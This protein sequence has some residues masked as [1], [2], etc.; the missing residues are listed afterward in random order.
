[1]GL[2]WALILRYQIAGPAPT[3]GG[4]KGGSKESKEAQKKRTSA[5]K[6]LLGWVNASL[7]K[8]GIR[9]FTTDW[10]D[11]RNLSALVDYCKPGLI[12]DHASLDP[13]NHLENVTKA[14]DIA[15][16]ELNVPQV[17]HPEDLAVDKPD[18]LSVMTYISGFCRPN[19][20]GPNSLLD[21]INERIPNIPATN[22]TTDWSDG[23]RLGALTDSVSGGEFPEADQMKEDDDFKNCQ[24]AMDAAHNLLG[25][26][27]TVPPEDF[28]EE[29]FDQLTRM[30]YLSQFRHAKQPNTNLASMM[31]AVG[32]GI[33][34]DS[35]EKE[36][37][38]L[39]RGPRIPKWA[40]LDARVTDS[41]GDE[42][43]LKRQSTSSKAASYL[44][45]PEK[46]GDYIIDIKL[47]S[48]PIPNS[49]F[50][51]S[52]TP[53][54]N[55]QGCVATGNGLSKARVGETSSFSVNCEQGGP[56][57]LMVEIEGPNGNVGTEMKEPK[58]RN[59]DVSFSPL[60]PGEH[61]ISINW[62]EK[63]I[64]NSPFTCI[65][66][67]P[68]KCTASGP[69]LTRASVEGPQTFNV[70]AE[71]AG[72]GKL[73]ATV[74]GPDGDV[75]IEISEEGKGNYKCTYSPKDKGPHTINISWSGV[76]I[77]G[78]P[79]KVNVT[80]PGDASKCVV[81]DL[82][83]GR[84]RALKTYSFKVDTSEAG[85]GELTASAH[86]PS[87]PESCTVK[88]TSNDVYAVNVTS[89]EVG[90]LRVEASYA[91]SPIPGSPFEFTVNDPRKVK[92]NR[93]AIESG[94]YQVKQPIDFRVSAQYAG[95]GDLSASVRGPE[96]EEGVEIKDQGDKTY[97]M[98]YSP[99]NGGSHA[100]NI[101]FDGDEIPDVPMRIFVEAGSMADNVVVTQPAP[102]K[103][104]A[105]IIEHPYT[106]K[107]NTDGA[108]EGTLTAT[109]HGARTGQ[110]PKVNVVDDGNGRYSVSIE[111]EEPDTYMV[112]IQ[113]GEENV[114]GSPFSLSV[115]DK[116]RPEKVV[117]IGPHYK[118]GSSAPIT[119]YVN[120]E[121]AG[122]GKLDATCLGKEVGPVSTEITEREPKKYVVSFLPPKFDIYSI[123]VLWSSENVTNSPFTVN[124]I[125]P[126]ASK[127][128]VVGP[129]IPEMSTNPIVLHVDASNAGNGKLAASA[130]GDTIGEVD[131]EIKETEPNKFDLSFLPADNEN[132]TLDV[133]W[134]DEAV[135]GSPFKIDS[136]TPD[137]DKVF[138]CEPPSAMLEAG[139]AIG[140]CFDTSQGGKGELTAI[141]KGH[142]VGEIP[143]VVRKRSMVK[144]KYDVRF[145]PPEP[146]VYVVS[147]LWGGK[148]VKGSPYTINLMPVDV[149][150][151]RVI[152]PTMPQGLDGP[153]E[154]MLQ[155]SGAGKG[156]VTGACV[157]RK[158]GDINVVIKET[159]TDIYQLGIEPTQ[160]DIFTFAVQY[161]GQN[162]NGSPFLIN[163][164]PPNAANV[165]VTEP[166]T[167]EISEPL[168][169]KVD[170]TDAG[171]GKM[172]ATCRGEKYGQ[173]QLDTFEESTALYDVSFTPHHA[174]HYSVTI[175]WDG[176][177]VPNSP[178]SV[179]LR[180]PMADQVKVGELHIPEEAGTGE[181]IWIDI[182]CSDA[183]HGPVKAEARGDLSGKVTVEADKIGKAKYRVKF[184]PKQADVYHFAIAYGDDQVPG[185]PFTVNLVPPQADLVKHTRTQM[186]EFEGGPV[187]LFFNTKEAGNGKLTADIAGETS[188]AA[189]TK[190]E[191]TSSTEY[192]VTFA[193][194][195]P[196]IYNAVILWSDK[197]IKGSPFKVD[198]RPALHPD[199]VECGQLTYTDVFKPVELPVDIHKA[200]PGKLTA[201]CV[202]DSGSTLPTEVQ[203]SGSPD[204]Y[205]V[206][207]V[208]KAQGNYN[209]S[210]FFEGT[211]VKGSPFSVDLK[212]VLET[213]DMVVL[214]PVE[215][216]VL[217]PEEFLQSAPPKENE[218]AA[219]PDELTAFI[220]QPLDMTVT[221]DDD[222]QRSGE[223]IATAHSEKTGPS[224]VKVTKNPDD[225]FNVHFNP[226][227]PDR[228]TIDV[229]LNGEHI[230]N[231][232]F[233][234]NYI[235]AID[236]LKCRIFGLQDIPAIP[237]VNEPIYFGVDAKDAGNS[238]LAVTSDGPSVEEKPTVLDVKESDKEAGVY[239][240]TYVPTAMGLHRVHLLW[241]G[242]AIPGSPLQFEVGDESK[243]QKFPFGKPVSMDIS[244][245]CKPGD[246]DAYAIHEDT[247]IKY[248]VK[249]NK[250]QKGK[251]KL[252]F[253]PKAPGIYAVYFLLKK[254]ELPGSPYRIRVLGPPNPS[255]VL[256]TELNN[257]G[258]VGEDIAFDVD[259][260]QAGSGEL[261]VRVTG[262]KE[263]KDSD[264]NVSPTDTEGN[265]SVKY[266]PRVVGDHAFH[267]S[268]AGAEVP[269]SPF[270]VKVIERN[271]DINKALSVNATNVVEVG[272]PAE[273][274]LSNL[275]PNVDE[276]YVTAQCS[277]EKSGPAEV[278]VEKED[279]GSYLVRFVPT[280]ADDYNLNVKLNK[281]DIKGSPFSIKAVE[282]GALSP[283]YAHP[284]GV[285]HSDVKAGLPVNVITPVEDAS[286]LTATVQGPYG[287]CEIST[288]T[289]LKGAVGLEFVPPLTGDYIVHAKRDDSDIVG[290]PFKVTAYG[291]DPDPSKVGI[292]D[293]DMDVFKKAIPFGKPAKFRITTTDAGPGTLNITSRGPG[294]AEVK[295][296]D[297][298]D[299]TYTCE[300]TPSIAGKYHIDILWNDDHIKG[301]P[302]LLT[303]KSK[304]SRVITGLN[305]ENENFRIGVPHR[306][307][308]HC[309]EVGDGIL[310]ILC[311]PQ[312]GGQVRLSPIPGGNSYQ[313]EIIPMEVGNHQVFVQY[314][315]KHILGSPF[316]VHFELRGDASKCRMVESSIEHQQEVED[317]VTFCISTEG[318]GK[319]K[320]TASVENTSTKE[321]T[322]VSVTQISDD[323][324]NV[325]FSPADGA[326][327][328][329][330]VKYDD[331]HILGSPFKLVFGPPETDASKCK[332]T[333]DGLIA[334]TS[335]K[336]TKFLVDTIDAGPGELGVA[337]DGGG[338]AVEP[339]ISAV[340]DTQMEVQF[341]PTKSGKYNVTVRWGEKEIP[342][343]PFTVDCY[344]PS[345]PGLF[346]VLKE[347]HFETLL[348]TPLEFSVQAA[349]P[350]AEGELTI[351]AQS[352]Q[353][354]NAQ[355]AVMSPENGDLTY[356]CSVDL[357][358]A[359][360]FM[361][362]VKW[363]GS[364]IKGS[365]FKARALTPPKPER[366][367]AY[368]PGLQ[369]GFIGQEGNFTVETGEGGS[370]TLQVKVHGPKGA[371]KI[372]M[373]RHPEN[374]RTILVRY[375]PN[376]IGKYN[377]DITWSETPIPGSPFEV[378]IAEQ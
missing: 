205:S 5:K 197:P 346:R 154:L 186:P 297:N 187:S 195:K 321:R 172:R 166:D 240:I 188:G 93:A 340:N 219:A 157:G 174:D 273:V 327:Y 267:V 329:L 42:V 194:D 180:P 270:P 92:V 306:F 101:K 21:W 169:F 373:R 228:Y 314:N 6:L 231:S 223:L 44:Y 359:G 279:D 150:K 352:V 325:D 133:T 288:K 353:N 207:F 220:G 309:G 57:E 304:K 126:D 301:S 46:A 252:G 152:G 357:P 319:G 308:L 76:P 142:R 278:T 90:P 361:V 261:G 15:E 105:Y 171:Y 262:P 214:Q 117:C 71:K 63:A 125:P 255:A 22:F 268:W 182:D 135:P 191:Q 23:Q 58:D 335:N 103:I 56:G 286:D 342:G 369:D 137:A 82:P 109:S 98:H 264:L 336:A 59:Y 99:S 374:E 149:N 365:P 118:V 299:G 176:E 163:T 212:P 108:G 70:K 127:C 257:E 300:F 289:D 181:H 362:H 305:L 358:E 334:C 151:L 296:F 24:E 115:E 52:H 322:P 102:S 347:G 164:H 124:I 323:R 41:N 227:K 318:A 284:E 243:L 141:C 131:L 190:I 9:N 326:E 281:E 51:V 256:V 33:T 110:K 45:T 86:G 83:E 303:F 64:P 185:S 356:K 295:V 199:L 247:N 206:S 128:I 156:K 277:G 201:S 253:Q 155:T 376:H 78:S 27:Q 20:A 283:D 147:V 67:D 116:P 371:F 274:R 238:K 367:K 248:K 276:D 350:P 60:E 378:N 173:V 167:I 265:Y 292:V 234:V 345:D 85:S 333:G 161:G 35:A 377:I 192:K 139:Q 113:W 310:E 175:E 19:A 48:T 366:V 293:E 53:P 28:A 96:G 290:S 8:N 375:D 112:N 37:N 349:G 177:E 165:R 226:T 25:I 91:N 104:G 189:P 364:H 324:Y 282:K 100:I 249:V 95:E 211:E 337:I 202:D 196:E 259:T 36:T 69:G 198:T 158:S 287:P 215:E 263:V 316:N 224:N 79:F 130:V 132:Y 62:D 88:E 183:G 170:A 72:P 216:S 122:A 77:P 7:P 344:D 280:V 29:N 32:P 111:A 140:I 80:A 368:G 68:K 341:L 120:T 313:C 30:A 168:H 16:Q 179:D 372:N 332:A 43:P 81:S 237:Q 10:N 217:I 232:P 355:G 119:L 193:P 285:A 34:G 75:P 73:S 134:S 50:H 18:E 1:M 343:S 239:H 298:K 348:G 203:R 39:I 222:D 242:E 123:S 94:S 339:T 136:S 148:Y 360:K 208:P 245:D 13:N 271:P 311:K 162:V 246:L 363:N 291:K 40:K 241:A 144:D 107:V 204:L 330:T 97:L 254:K 159:S 55:V 106:Y 89:A 251:F 138:I 4:S 184:P 213:V 17:L 269:G 84:L 38:F 31:K 221:A 145:T 225:S 302:Y 317:N 320:L 153:V 114:P 121:N 146:D 14:M 12:P 272:Q 74:Q 275:G 143:I 307:K 236:V 351:M 315:G 200:G 160:A 11:G 229:K 49:P 258:C 230:P 233:I 65:V 210:V 66:I 3:E 178:F 54:S 260:S 266:L 294:K 129:E 218:E 61:N 244:V 47:N 328:L 209:L 250:L 312:S 87:V 26:Q 2:L 354:K 338:E 370:G 331:Q 235:P